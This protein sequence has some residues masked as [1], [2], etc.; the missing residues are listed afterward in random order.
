M[1]VRLL[2]RAA[3]GSE[4][5]L[6]EIDPFTFFANFNRAL[7]RE[8]RIA[9]WRFLRERWQLSAP[10]PAD[11]EGLPLADNQRAWFM[12]W[13]AEREPEHVELLWELFGQAL[14]GGAGGVNRETF[15]R[16]LKLRSLGMAYLSFGLSW[17]RPR[18]FLGTDHNT[19]ALARELG[20]SLQPKD[21]LSYT[22]WLGL[23]RPLAPD[24]FPAF[25]RE[26]L[27]RASRPQF[28][29]PDPIFE[30]L[31]QRFRT[32]MPGFQRFAEPGELDG[33]ELAYKRKGLAQFAANVGP[34]R[35]RAMVESGQGLQLIVEFRKYSAN[36]ANFRSWTKTF[37]ETPE[38]VTRVLRVLLDVAAKPWTGPDT[39]QP[40][41]A[42]AEADGLKPSWD[43]VA[44]ALWLLRPEDYFPIKIEDYRAI[45]EKDLGQALPAGRASAA[46]FA[47]V[48]AFGEAFR[49]RL[50]PFAPRDWTDVQS[51]IYVVRHLSQEAPEVDR[52]A[53]PFDEI[54]DT[55][56]Q[57]ETVFA[58]FRRAM[59]KLGLGAQSSADER[60]ALTLPAQK[61]SLL[62]FNFGNFV[63]CSFLGGS[64]GEARFEFT[65][66]MSQT[67]REAVRVSTMS[68]FGRKADEP[69]FEL[70]RVPLV[71]MEQSH[72]LAAFDA[73]LT[74]LRK[75]FSGWE[76]SPYR[77]SHRPE[78]LRMIFHDSYRLERLKHGLPADDRGSTTTPVYT[79]EH[80]LADLF[81]SEAQLRTML[82]TLRHKQNLILQGA[83]GV[84]KSFIA[85]RLAFLL[86]GQKD[87]SRVRTLQFH[88]SYGYE[89]F[90]QGWRPTESGGFALR[91]GHFYEFCRRAQDDPE[92]DYVLIID[93]INR[94][95]L[96]R[97]FG[98]LM[99]LLEPEKRGP[100]FA[101]PLTYSP[102]ETF[103]VPERLH[104]VGLMNTAD[105]SLAMVDYALRRRFA[106][107][108]LEPGF[109]SANFATVLSQRGA[110]EAL[111]G[112]IRARLAEVN[113][114]IAEDT[115]SLGP[116]YVIG[117]S[118]FVPRGQIDDGE[119]WY[120]AI[121]E[122][123][124]LPL[125]QEY[126]VDDPARLERVR[127]LLLA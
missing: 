86:L 20:V 33:E 123:E 72:V 16:C 91:S 47:A 50:Q 104:V 67:P 110:E 18:L 41:F 79:I 122:W 66:L 37:G 118:F 51:F 105:R 48:R 62:R 17:I 98:E 40:F 54:F 71:S 103:Y 114:L 102:G 64:A 68:Q 107:I 87:R 27:H 2:D 11:F 108:P 126:W 73:S 82:A 59:L 34:D 75:R 78:V 84:G 60:I 45:A 31:L 95:N 74:E 4:I 25:S 38:V 63:M 70:V 15:D 30:K 32:R 58:W 39:L 111:I 6:A 3:D 61:P 117:H 83:P 80:A 76:K 92:H 53:P 127:G 19:L 88:Q 22:E 119:S 106:F 99:V 120:R 115:A 65:S 100:G 36:L 89:D 81:V 26:A 125:I 56:K 101:M 57:A 8:N 12:P 43:A 96:S 121:V 14:R 23:I 52:L 109:E 93:E 29:L 85:E 97:I 77:N 90:I 24:G 49:E 10:V 13:K 113:R 28:D 46:G 35:A 116:G 124:I 5:P 112:R 42:A 21:Y 94:G 9:L 69:E 1:T 44:A 7:R 55:V